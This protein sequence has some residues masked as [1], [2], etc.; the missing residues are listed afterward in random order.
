MT[1][2]TDPSVPDGV[3]DVTYIERT[4]EDGTT[5]WDFHA[6]PVDAPLPTA[7]AYEWMEDL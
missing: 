2:M 5:K 1:H 7:A 4:D 3:Y 6:T